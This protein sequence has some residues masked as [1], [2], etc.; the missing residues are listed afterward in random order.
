MWFQWFCLFGRFS[1]LISILSYFKSLSYSS[2]WVKMDYINFLLC[3]CG[4][5]PS[6]M[7]LL[8]FQLLC[9]HT[10]PITPRSSENGDESPVSTFPW[11]CP[12]CHLR[13]CFLGGLQA[14]PIPEA[15]VLTLQ[16]SQ[17]RCSYTM[18]MLQVEFFSV[19]APTATRN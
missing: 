3:F 6:S 12:P 2:P 4:S 14:P 5:S 1:S 17:A 19:F 15:G 13:H 16:A 18:H 8:G 11:G 7:K 9:S 10:V